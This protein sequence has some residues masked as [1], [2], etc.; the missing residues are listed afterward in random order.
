MRETPPL[1]TYG[2]GVSL[3]TPDRRA[4]RLP[5]VIAALL[6]ATVAVAG[7]ALAAFLW[8]ATADYGAMLAAARDLI[9][10][11]VARG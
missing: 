4:S 5:L 8:L 6:V 3:R 7:L 1:F 2:T 11:F 10:A 9:T